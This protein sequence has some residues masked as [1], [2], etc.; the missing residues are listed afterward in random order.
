MISNGKHAGEARSSA[1]PLPPA[2]LQGVKEGKELGDVMDE[3]F[4]TVS[5]KQQ[6]VAIG[7]LTKAKKLRPLSP[8]AGAFA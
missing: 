6:G 2:T 4:Q 5:I 3:Q 8:I 1:L 7:L